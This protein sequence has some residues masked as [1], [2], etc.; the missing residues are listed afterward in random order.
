M[1]LCLIEFVPSYLGREHVSSSIRKSACRS[2]LSVFLIVVT[3]SGY[4]RSRDKSQCFSTANRSV[5][6]LNARKSLVKGKL[7]ASTLT[8]LI[9]GHGLSC[10]QLFMVSSR[11]FSQLTQ[12]G[13]DLEGLKLALS[14]RLSLEA[15]I[16]ST[17]VIVLLRAL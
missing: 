11:R 14:G 15:L 4:L 12:L 17:L 3:A 16:S 9:N 10:L 8:Y 7:V 2:R 5:S 6:A 1:A 13:F